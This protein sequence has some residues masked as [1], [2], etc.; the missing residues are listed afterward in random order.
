MRAACVSPFFDRISYEPEL[1]CAT[2]TASVVSRGELA[3]DC[4]VHNRILQ[5]LSLIEQWWKLGRFKRVWP[6]EVD[7]GT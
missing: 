2:I 3:K 5:V 4:C 7:S 6:R 1:V